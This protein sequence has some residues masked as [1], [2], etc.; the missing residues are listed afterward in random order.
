MHNEKPLLSVVVPVRNAA[1]TLPRTL[2]ALS[3]S[4][5]QRDKWELIVVDDGSADDSVLTAGAFADAI[6]RLPAN[7]SGRPHGAPY[8]RNRGFEM[9]RGEIVVFVDPDI[10]VAADALRRIW[11]VLS[12]S[13]DVGAISGF[14][15]EPAPDD[16]TIRKIAVLRM[17]HGHEAGG[18]DGDVFFLRFGAIRSSLLVQL[19]LFNEWQAD[20]P[21][22]EMVELA[23]RIRQQGYRVVLLPEINGNC[24]RQWT[25][26]RL[27]ADALRD[28][29]TPWTMPQN[30]G[31]RSHSAAAVSFRQRQ[32]ASELLAWTVLIGGL[33]FAFTPEGI[34]YWPSKLFVGSVVALVLLRLGFYR[35]VV[36]R[37]GSYLALPA[38]A[39]D[40]FALLASGI[41]RARAS[42]TRALVGSPRPDATTEAFTEVGV[43][44]WPPIPAKR[45]P[46]KDHEPW[47]AAD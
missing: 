9:S 36:R 43:Q 34:V 12:A 31:E 15:A 41:A 20:Y 32:R 40:L 5:F 6:I 7:P 22:A 11:E 2:S 26:G 38:A 39:V 8:S 27:I 44:I 10:E 19:E 46:P 14:L 21:V 17:L 23:E 47:I 3:A 4:D 1:S 33:L 18:R 13:D 24:L 37:Q 25:F 30:G 35:R 28:A 42:L 16:R 45:Y 29:G